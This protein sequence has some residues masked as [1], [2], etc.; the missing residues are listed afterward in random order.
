[1][2]LWAGCIAGA[3]EEET[4]RELLGAAGFPDIGVEVTRVYDMGEL[5]TSKCCGSAAPQTSFAELAASG[6]RLVSAFVRARKPAS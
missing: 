3:L 4:Y 1:M 5:A 6:G 2:E